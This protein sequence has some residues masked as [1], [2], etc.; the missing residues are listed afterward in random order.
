[1]AAFSAD[2]R[3]TEAEWMDTE[4]V[5]FED[6][7]AC[8]EDLA[9]V[10]RLSLGYRPTLGFLERLRRT[11]RLPSGRPLRILDAGSGYGDTLRAV[12]GWAS[13]RSVAVELS[14]VDINP[15][16]TRAAREATPADW[17]VRYHTADIFSHVPTDPPDLVISALF[18]HHLFGA[19]LVRFIA[20]SEETARLGWF[21][22]DL[23]RDPV[24]FHGF[25]LITSVGRWH[26]FVRH[27]GPVSI[28]RG[29]RK[30]DWLGVLAA[31]DIDP[32][33]VSL[34]WWLPYRLCVGRV[35]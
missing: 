20:W 29:F 26:R 17:P 12:A 18:T 32:R 30:A 25:Q 2:S 11:G 21:V 10:N 31:A 23:H 5:P 22:N 24:S 3:S 14:G 34:S 8:L 6:F 28:A 35:K 16:S 7:L 33:S 9:R 27:D 1:M 4:A 15:W 13:R 19:D